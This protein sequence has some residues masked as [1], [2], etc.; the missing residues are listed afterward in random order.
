[1][2]RAPGAARSVARSTVVGLALG[3]ATPD[4]LLAV[5]V[6][7]SVERWDDALLEA[8]PVLESVIIGG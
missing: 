8:E 2:K 4:G 1:M 7:G 5:M 6:G 3:L